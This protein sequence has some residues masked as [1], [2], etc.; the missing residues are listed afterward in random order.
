MPQSLSNLAVHL[1]FSTKNRAAYLQDAEL[2]PELY[3]Y[4]ATILR[5]TVDCPA[6]KIGGVADHVHVLF[7]LS[8]TQTVANVVEQAK[9]ETSKWIKKQASDLE[10]FSWQAGYG[11]FAVSES[12]VAAVKRYIDR[13]EEHHRKWSFQD[14]FRELCRKHQVEIDERYVWD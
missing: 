2:R 8:R 9:K 13:Q 1:V 5:N 4:M 7:Q 6:M 11:A 10:T 12:N 14:E 3:A